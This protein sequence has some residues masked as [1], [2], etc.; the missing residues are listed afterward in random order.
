MN[1]SLIHAV[2]EDALTMKINIPVYAIK[3]L[4]VQLV[5]KVSKSSLKVMVVDII[6]YLMTGIYE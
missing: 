2:M 1:A 5:T 4:L 3:D 6:Y